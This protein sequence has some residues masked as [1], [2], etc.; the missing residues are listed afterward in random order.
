MGRPI[1]HKLFKYRV[2]LGHILG[3]FEATRRIY[4]KLVLGIR[5]K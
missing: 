2:A 1:G 3:R 4:E 5:A